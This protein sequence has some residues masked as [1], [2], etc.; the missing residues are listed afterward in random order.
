MQINSVK[1]KLLSKVFYLSLPSVQVTLTWTEAPVLV[2]FQ[3]PPGVNGVLWAS[4]NIWGLS[5]PWHPQPLVK[6]WLKDTHSPQGRASHF[7]VQPHCPREPASSLESPM[8]TL[9]GSTGSQASGGRLFYFPAAEL[10]GP[11]DTCTHHTQ[12]HTP[13]RT[14][15][16]CVFPCVQGW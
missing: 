6:S 14:S 11:R 2:A 16:C 7:L 4:G 15:Q 1:A 13:S 9:E 5:S 3:C 12:V 8:A 10:S